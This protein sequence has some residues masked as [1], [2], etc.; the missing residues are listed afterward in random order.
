M[1]AVPPFLGER[2]NWFLDEMSEKKERI[3]A[4]VNSFAGSKRGQSRGWFRSGSDGGINFEVQRATSFGEVS[5][6]EIGNQIRAGD[7]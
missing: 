1:V 6:R 3:D 7:G 4:G 5:S 2:V